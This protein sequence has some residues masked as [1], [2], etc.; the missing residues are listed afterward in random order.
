[1]ILSEFVEGAVGDLGDF[2]PKA[3]SQEL[4]TSPC[5]L[6]DCKG[7]YEEASRE[8]LVDGPWTVGRLKS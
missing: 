8:C 6:D 4:N 7:Q 5:M 1:M 3:D 2:A